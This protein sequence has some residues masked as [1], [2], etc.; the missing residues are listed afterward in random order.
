MFIK[1]STVQEGSEVESDNS[2]EL[3]YFL[4]GLTFQSKLLSD[5]LA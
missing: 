5:G 1:I 4:V 2:H 3:V